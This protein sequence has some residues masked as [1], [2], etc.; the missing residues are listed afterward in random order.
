MGERSSQEG[1]ATAAWV[2]IHEGGTISTR[3]IHGPR[4][5]GLAHPQVLMLLQQ[6]P[7]AA[8]CDRY[9][10]WHGRAPEHIWV[11]ILPFQSNTLLFEC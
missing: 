11:S 7:G 6:L 4:M 8:L 9:K 5:F 1:N 3:G 10:G 2:K